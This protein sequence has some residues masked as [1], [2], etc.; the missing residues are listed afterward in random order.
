MGAFASFADLF[1]WFA[2]LFGKMISTRAGG[3]IASALLF[4]GLSFTSYKFAVAPF[5]QLIQDTM[6][7][8]GDLIAWAG[9]LGIDKAVTIV[10]SAIG[11]KYGVQSVRAVLT[12][13]AA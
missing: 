7:G 3:W 13:G 9:F 2:G 1:K 6:G 5:R 12:K 11:V 8:G 4:L 10:L